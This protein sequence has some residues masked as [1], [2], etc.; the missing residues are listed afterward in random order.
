MN[1]KL[2]K[3]ISDLDML[4][5]SYQTHTDFR[6]RTLIEQCYSYNLLKLERYGT[7][8]DLQKYRNIFLDMTEVPL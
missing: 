7:V 4:A 5:Q 2:S 1:P 8:L 3:I 6:K